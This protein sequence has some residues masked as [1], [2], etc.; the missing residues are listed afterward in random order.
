MKRISASIFAFVLT[1][2]CCISASAALLRPIPSA[3][4]QPGG[5]ASQPET[6]LETSQSAIAPTPTPKPNVYEQKGTGDKILR[7][8]QTESTYSVAHITNKGKSNFVVWHYRADDTKNLLVNTIGNYDGYVLM[9]GADASR[10]QINSKGDWSIVIN[11]VEQIKDTSFSGYGDFVTGAFVAPT[12]SWVISNEGDHNFIVWQYVLNGD[13]KD[14]LV[15]TIGMY[16]GEQISTVKRGT[17]CFFEI[18]SDGP[19]SI[20][21]YV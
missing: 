1:V 12:D 17:L 2:N 18:K 5:V 10:L 9:T 16:S 21:P 13:K 3:T 20:T 19:W 11:P 6:A 8:V 7:D 4:P 14:L 15:N